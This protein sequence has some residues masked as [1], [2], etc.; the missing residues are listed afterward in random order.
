M[1]EVSKTDV[2]RVIR[3]EDGDTRNSLLSNKIVKKL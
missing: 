2:G 3:V 1:N